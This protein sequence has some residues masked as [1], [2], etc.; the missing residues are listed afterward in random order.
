LGL[1]FIIV[2]FSM[3]IGVIQY[4]IGDVVSGIWW[5]LFAI[6]V[7]QTREVLKG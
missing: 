4:S 1:L 5:L 7:L 6:A 3:V 2:L